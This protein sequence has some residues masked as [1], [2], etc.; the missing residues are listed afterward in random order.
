MHVRVD[1][2]YKDKPLKTQIQA[3]RE[4]KSQINCMFLEKSH[5][6]DRQINVANPVN[7]QNKL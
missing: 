5:C 1:Y 2:R 7:V 3:V 6:M 4:D